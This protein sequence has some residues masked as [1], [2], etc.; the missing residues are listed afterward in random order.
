M[1]AF[2]EEGLTEIHTADYGDVGL[3]GAAMVLKTL[4]AAN[5]TSGLIVELGCGPGLSARQLVDAGFDVVAC[6]ASASMVNRA[7]ALVPEVEIIHC[8]LEQFVWPAE[9]VAVVAFGEVLSYASSAQAFDQRLQQLLDRTR[10]VLCAGGLFVFDLVLAG[11]TG[12]TL[13]RHLH[14]DRAAYELSVDAVEDPTHRT[15]DRWIYGAT[16]TEPVMVIDEQHRQITSEANDITDLLHQCGFSADV[17]GDY[18]KTQVTTPGWGVFLSVKL[19][20]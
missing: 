13:K 6:D 18:R 2:Y 17:F 20:Q 1:S 16:K 3:S 10:Q 15:L 4:H 9:A 11:R 19:P 8:D 12:P 5:V 14:H 7:Q